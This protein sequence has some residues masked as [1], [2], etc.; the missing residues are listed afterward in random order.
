MAIRS[1]DPDDSTL[2][3]LIDE[4]STLEGAGKPAP[5]FVCQAC[6]QAAGHIIKNG[7]HSPRPGRRT[8]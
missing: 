8:V 6:P 1:H 3:L 4:P 5:F 7:A 2:Q